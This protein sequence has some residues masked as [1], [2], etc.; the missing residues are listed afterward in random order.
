MW[1]VNTLSYNSQKNSGSHYRNFK[2]TG[3]IILLAMVY[4]E[5]EFLFADVGMNSR[6]SE[7]GSWSKSLL[8]NGFEINALN[9][10]NQMLLRGRKNPITYV[11]TG[12][13]ALFCLRIR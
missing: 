5:Y 12:D 1:M 9:L 6:N 2:G 8:K 7:D 3:G 13:R 11:C 4:P 10:P